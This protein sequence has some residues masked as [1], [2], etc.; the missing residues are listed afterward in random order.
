MAKTKFV[1]PLVSVGV[2]VSKSTLAVA[3][4]NKEQEV[5]DWTVPNSRTGVRSFLERLEDFGTAG[6]VPIVLEST[7]DFHLLSAL[8]VSQAGHRVKCLN[9]I[10]TKQY[11]RSS[12]RGAKTDKVD[13]RRLA[14]IGRQEVN[15]PDFTATTKDIE[16]RKKLSSLAKLHHLKQELGA[17][18]RSVTQAVETLGLALGLPEAEQALE[19]LEKQIASLEA[20]LVAEVDPRLAKLVETTKGF[21]LRQAAVLSAFLSGRRF[22][23]RDQLVAFAGLDVRVR[24]SGTWRG[25]AILS[26]RG[27]A[28]LRRTLFHVGR[29][30]ALWEPEYQNYYRRKRGQDGHHHTTVV[31][32]CARKFLRRVH[33]VLS[34]PTQSVAYGYPQLSLVKEA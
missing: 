27:D 13:A 3:L 1:S 17:H 21:S 9:P 8:M 32:A 2:D 25:K 5:R 16:R 31:L 28:F 10:I 4:L 23:H 14:Q 19:L 26:K 7:G 18:L 12:I 20:E 22:T 6:A 15:L 24:E 11:E 33:A 29:G 30:L 34:R